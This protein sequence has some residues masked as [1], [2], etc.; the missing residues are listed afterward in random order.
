MGMLVYNGLQQF[1]A[2]FTC[3]R[4]AGSSVVDYICGR[5]LPTSFIVC[6]LTLERYSDHRVL[7]CTLPIP[8]LVDLNAAPAVS[9]FRSEYSWVSGDPHGEGRATHLR[10]AEHT[11][12]AEFA[13]LLNGIVSNPDCSVDEQ[14]G[15]IE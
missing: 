14:L 4:H 6:D 1:S 8:S 11:N 2:D 12:T 7:C 5:S 13:S 15:L 3:S 10:W 9:N